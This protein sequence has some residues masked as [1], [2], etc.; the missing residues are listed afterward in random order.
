MSE[1]IIIQCDY[2]DGEC[3]ERFEGFLLTD[4]NAIFR[5]KYLSKKGWLV[6]D[7]KHYCPEHKE[8]ALKAEKE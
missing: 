5:N 1:M 4:D 3:L 7:S 6:Q 8:Q 2:K